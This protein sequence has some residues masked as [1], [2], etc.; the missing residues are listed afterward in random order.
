MLEVLSEYEKKASDK[1]KALELLQDEATRKL[2]AAYDDP[3]FKKNPYVLFGV[4][5]HAGTMQFGHYRA[6]LRDIGGSHGWLQFNDERVS[7]AS[8][9]VVLREARGEDS[10][11]AA[12]ALYVREEVFTEWEKMVVQSDF[13]EV[14]ESTVAKVEKRNLVTEKVESSPPKKAQKQ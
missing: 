7:P 11:N 10:L 2:H 9:E 1:L 6:Y 4:W 14:P 13:I 5:L 12:F 3:K 8:E